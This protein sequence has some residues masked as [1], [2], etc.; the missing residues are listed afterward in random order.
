MTVFEFTR[1]YGGV[2]FHLEDHVQRFLRGAKIMGIECPT[3][4]D[5]TIKAVHHITSK[6]KFGHSGMKFYLTIGESGKAAGYSFSGN[7]EFTPHLMILEEEFQPALYQRGAGLKTVPFIRHL[8]EVKNINYS[9]GFVASRKLD[10]EKHEDILYLH[11]DGYVT[12]TTTSNFLCVIDGNLLTPKRDMLLGVPRTIL[13]DLAKKLNIPTAETD[14]T[15]ADVKRASEAFITGSF[16][17]MMPV[18]LI[19]DIPFKTTMDGPIF[20][21]LRKAF[22]NYINDYCQAKAA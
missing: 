21:K 10:K 16:L 3:S 14:I 17:E 19:D 18:R 1:I 9:A 7:D 11:H 13:L 22:T 20:S 15:L 2:P 4:A 12:E 5:E 8:P 6:N